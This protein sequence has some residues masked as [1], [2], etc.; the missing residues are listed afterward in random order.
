MIFSTRVPGACT[1][2]GPRVS[3][4]LQLVDEVELVPTGNRA[5]VDHDVGALGRRRAAP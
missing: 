5:E 1:L 2:S 4:L 3:G